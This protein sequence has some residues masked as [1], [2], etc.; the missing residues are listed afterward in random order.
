M[1]YFIYFLTRNT[2]DSKT[3]YTAVA[4]CVLF[5]PPFFTKDDVTDIALVDLV[6]FEATSEPAFTGSGF[7]PERPNLNSRNAPA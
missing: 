2:F 4:F 3:F 6:S 5:P 1:N 7:A